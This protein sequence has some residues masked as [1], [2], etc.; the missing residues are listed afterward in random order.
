MNITL[1][2]SPHAKQKLIHKAC[3]DPLIKFITVVAGRQSGKSKAAQMQV[4]K[5]GFQGKVKIWVVSPTYSQCLKFFNDIHKP[6]QKSGLIRKSNKS[7]G[8]LFLEFINGTIIEFKS[9]AAGNSLR[10]TTLDFLVLDEAAF[11]SETILNEVLLPMILTKPKSKVLFVSTPKGKNWLYKY[12][13]KTGEKYFSLRFTSSENLLADLTVISEFK[14]IMPPLMFAQE[15]EAEFVDSCNVFS[16]V[17]L[18][19]CL[20]NRESYD[21]ELW[22]GID[23][24]LIND[25]TCITLM[26]AEGEMIYKESFTNVDVAELRE[27]IKNV[28]KRFNI[29]KCLIELNNQGLPIYQDLKID[30]GEK[31]LGFN[32][33]SKSKPEIINNLIAAFNK[34]EI[35]I[36]DDEKLK[37]ELGDFSFKYSNTGQMTF[38]AV[39]GHDDE[40]MSLAI[41]W[42]CLNKHKYI[43]EYPICF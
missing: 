35:M 37:N 30:L 14:K 13:M 3:S 25:A 18:L 11:I 17:E 41:A 31:L 16:N 5:W 12:F 7:G 27:R 33:T 34:K 15:F 42:E 23:I 9:A 4:I 43:I 26:S 40:V 8:E 10:G 21:G 6:L 24:G 20:K 39:T 38:A 28:F 32:T 36:I 29:V 2:Y 22:G 19:A 1:N